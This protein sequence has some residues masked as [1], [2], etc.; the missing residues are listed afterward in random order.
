ML[1]PHYQTIQSPGQCTAGRGLWDTRMWDLGDPLKD[2]WPA[3]PWAAFTLLWQEESRDFALD[4][5]RRQRRKRGRFQA[6]F[7]AA[8]ENPKTQSHGL[9]LSVHG[10]TREKPLCG[11]HIALRAVVGHPWSLVLPVWTKGHGFW[12]PWLHGSC[13]SSGIH[14]LEE[15]QQR[16]WDGPS[17]RTQGGS[18]LHMWAPTAGLGVQPAHCAFTERGLPGHCG[19]RHSP[20]EGKCRLF[21]QSLPWGGHPR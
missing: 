16:T 8:C 10:Q 6:P 21:A 5:P 2:L 13:R 19:T 1:R 3:V 9:V 20:N 12:A 11:R 4:L 18:V 14:V 17:V 15:Q 7:R